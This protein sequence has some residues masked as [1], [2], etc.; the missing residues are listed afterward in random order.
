MR[1]IVWRAVTPPARRGVNAPVVPAHQ[2]DRL[3]DRRRVL[4]AAFGPQGVDAALDLQ[5]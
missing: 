5:R 2:A 3:A 4:D 1:T